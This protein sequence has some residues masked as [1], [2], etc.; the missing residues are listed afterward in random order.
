VRLEFKCPTL[1][2]LNKTMN[3]KRK[4]KRKH[5]AL[6]DDIGMIKNFIDMFKEIDIL[7]YIT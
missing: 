4:S 2:V 3:T 6:H 7:N 5:T 1:N